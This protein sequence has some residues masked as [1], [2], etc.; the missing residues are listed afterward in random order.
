MSGKFSG[1][2]TYKLVSIGQ[3]MLV[4]PSLLLLGEPT[5][6]LDSITAQRI[7][8]TLQGLARGRRTVVT[9]IHQ[10]SSWLYQMFNKLVVL[11]DG[12]PIY[13]GSASWALKYFGSIGYMPGG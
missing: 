1:S 5:S 8:A 3:E 6:G 4:N 7:V 13:S 9:T 11:S 10:P 2:I 12:C